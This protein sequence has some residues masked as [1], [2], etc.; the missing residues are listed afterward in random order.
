[1]D[2]GRIARPKIHPAISPD[3]RWSFMSGATDIVSM[4][5]WLTHIP[6]FISGIKAYPAMCHG[7]AALRRKTKTIKNPAASFLLRTMSLA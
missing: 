2:F 6:C 1:L 5:D 4:S 7:Y 3:K